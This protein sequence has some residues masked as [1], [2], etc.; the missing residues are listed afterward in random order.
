MTTQKIAQLFGW[1]FLL[2]GVLGFVPVAIIGGTYGMDTSMMLG[3]FPVNVIHNVVHVAFGVW[4]IMAAK[5]ADGATMFC[6]AGGVIYLA[7]G[8]VGFVMENPLGLVPLGGNDRF[9]HLVLGAVLA[10]FGF[11]ASPAKATA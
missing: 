9:L 5:S 6:K 1:V 8:V 3:L 10:Y 11:M 2:V 4:G 7:L